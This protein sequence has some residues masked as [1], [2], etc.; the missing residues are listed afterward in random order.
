[1]NPLLVREVQPPLIYV[2][3]DGRLRYTQSN[4]HIYYFLLS[5]LFRLPFSI[6]VALLEK[7]PSLLSVIEETLFVALLV[8]HPPL[9]AKV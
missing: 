9:A 5:L 7:H 3:G 4:K 2:G 8:K 1:M 6:F